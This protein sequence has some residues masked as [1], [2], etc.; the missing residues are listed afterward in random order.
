MKPD[1][2]FPEELL[3]DIRERASKACDAA[4]ALAWAINQMRDTYPNYPVHNEIDWWWNVTM[5]FSQE[6]HTIADRA[7][8][9]ADAED[10]T[11]EGGVE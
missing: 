3:D 7:E 1:D 4:Y 11:A 2:K 6:A 8:E 5:Q 9:L 10:E